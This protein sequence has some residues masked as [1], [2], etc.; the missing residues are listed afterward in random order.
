[1][2]CGSKAAGGSRLDSD[3]RA[4]PFGG[5]FVDPQPYIY[6]R[7]MSSVLHTPLLHTVI[8][9][10]CLIHK[11]EVVH[12]S[13]ISTPQASPSPRAKVDPK[14]GDSDTPSWME[15]SLHGLVSAF[16]TI[17]QGGSLALSFR[18][19]FFIFTAIF[20]RAVTYS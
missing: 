8:F 5:P 2:D 19:L 13:F 12:I 1:M 18:Q 4:V 9:S 3:G 6:V 16:I 10:S 7:N 20:M 11:L 14:D 15:R 17:L